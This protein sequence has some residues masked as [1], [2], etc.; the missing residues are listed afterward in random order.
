MTKRDRIINA[1]NHLKMPDNTRIAFKRVI[2]GG[3]SMASC[4]RKNQFLGS[5]SDYM[6]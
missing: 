3:H 1:L 5:K 4:F 2:L 6:K